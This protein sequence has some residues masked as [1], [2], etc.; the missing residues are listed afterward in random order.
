MLSLFMLLR[1]HKTKSVI[2][3]QG[4]ECQKLPG[5]LWEQGAGVWDVGSG[6]ASTRFVQDSLEAQVGLGKDC[7]SHWYC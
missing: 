1:N 6:K 5:V 7:G 4:I 3:R 2:A